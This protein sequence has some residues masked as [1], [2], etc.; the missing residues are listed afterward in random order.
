MIDNLLPFVHQHSHR[1]K[2]N[3]VYQFLTGQNIPNQLLPCMIQVF[4][5]AL[6]LSKI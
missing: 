3:M 6:C 5:I 4:I 2:N 1:M